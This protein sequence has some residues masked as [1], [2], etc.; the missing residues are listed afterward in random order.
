M[1]LAA[2]PRSLFTAEYRSNEKGREEESE[3]A[4]WRRGA[5]ARPLAGIEVP[6]SNALLAALP[7]MLTEKQLRR[8]VAVESGDTVEIAHTR[9]NLLVLTARGACASAQLRRAS[10]V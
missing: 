4:P 6:V 5:G 7:K 2:L 3:G 10:V 8:I 1:L 9:D